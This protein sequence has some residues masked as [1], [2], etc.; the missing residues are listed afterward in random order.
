MELPPFQNFNYFFLICVSGCSIIVCRIVLS[1]NYN[2]YLKKRLEH[3]GVSPGAFLMHCIGRFGVIPANFK[4]I[5]F[6]L[7]RIE[8]KSENQRRRIALTMG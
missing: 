3:T 8:T 1:M 7:C 4:P 2:K 5:N 6:S